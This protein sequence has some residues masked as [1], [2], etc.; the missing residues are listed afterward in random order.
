MKP[1]LTELFA[2]LNEESSFCEELFASIRRLLAWEL[3]RR[4]AGSGLG[5]SCFGCTDWHTWED[6]YIRG[7]TEEVLNS[8]GPL[9][10]LAIDCYEYA[11]IRR[12]SSLREQLDVKDNINGLI[13][14]NVRNFVTERQ[15]QNDP[16][17]TKTYRNI[18]A[19][20][21]EL[22]IDGEWRAQGLSRGVVHND[23]RLFVNGAS[24]E[25]ATSQ[26]ELDEWMG[27]LSDTFNIAREIG[28]SVNDE[29]QTRLVELLRTQG[30]RFP[31]VFFG[32]LAGV[33]KKRARNAY[34]GIRYRENDELAWSG[35][36][37]EE[38]GRRDM[39]RHCD[40]R[41]DFFEEIV[42]V[43]GRL[44]DLRRA[45]QNSGFYAPVRKRLLKILD[46]LE[47]AIINDS[48]EKFPSQAEMARR[49]GVSTSTYNDD[50]M[51][52]RELYFR[53]ISDE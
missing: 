7:D 10:D 21:E 25:E 52:L 1:T 53:E 13:R 44:S 17:G 31:C 45:V 2:G 16:C 50:I 32:D 33:W 24:E 9:L 48:G 43:Q 6:L 15:R 38:A 27:T 35:G 12:Y 8:T 40:D 26:G 20:V 28:A 5:P 29:V 11:V 19:A 37:D 22:L 14:L 23:T 30:E 36:G 34:E 51:R 49:L 42:E 47:S 18:R 4:G 39:I 3:R 41:F 46:V